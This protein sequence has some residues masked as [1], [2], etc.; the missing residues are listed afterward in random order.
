MKL[1]DLPNLPASL[2]DLLDDRAQSL[3]GK[4]FAITPDEPVTYRALADHSKQIATHLSDR[5]QPGERVVIM[6]PVS[7]LSLGIWFAMSRLGAID[8]TINP[9]YKGEMLLRLVQ[10]ASPTLCIIDDTMRSQFDEACRDYIDPADVIDPATLTQ[11]DDTDPGSWTVRA[12]A[13]R[14]IAAI[15]FTSGTTGNSKGVMVSQHQELAFGAAYAEI[16]RLGP[17]DTTY[18]FLPFFHIA[19]RFTA[20]G[21]MI[22]GGCMVLRRS[23]SVSAF[24]D[25][26]RAHDATVVSAVG[27]LCHM[28]YGQPPSENDADNSLRLIYAVPVPWEF[29]AE[30]EARFGLQLI[31]GYGGTETNLVAYSRLDEPCPRGAIGKPSDHFEI[32]LQ[33]QSGRAVPPGSAG[34]IC[35]RPRYPSTMLT[36][37]FGLPDKTLEVFQD[38][39]F[40]TG[41]AGRFDAD[42]YLYFLDRM[43][44]TIRRRGENIS[45]YEVERM[46]NQ[47]PAVAESAVIATPSELDEDEVK[48]VIVLKFG[49]TA[50][51]EQLFLYAT[52]VLPYFMVPRFIEFRSE[53][54][55]TPTLKVT[56]HTLVADGNGPA[57]WDC[58][59]NG[60]RISSRGFRQ[61]S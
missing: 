20:L 51:E 41:D 61:K 28:L 16:T 47:H 57:T 43:R 31:E 45:S 59:K 29:K 2:H 19:G 23:F 36:G 9:A 6:M 8:T 7:R 27:G 4:T 40:H 38:L 48:A 14:D 30:F 33:D 53:L 11:I 44:D 25:D 13:P 58:E 42:G 46:L 12:V 54:P 37:Y 3:G 10:T 50:S 49:Q 22:A 17:D 55:R 1:F 32:Q 35:I 21:T 56:K 5:V 52:K 18:N 34:E 24:W 26:I 15:L 39:W 60:Y